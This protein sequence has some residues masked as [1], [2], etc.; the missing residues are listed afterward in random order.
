MQPVAGGGQRTEISAT[1]PGGMS[2]G[3]TVDNATGQVLGVN[4]YSLVGEEGVEQNFNMITDTSAP[5][6]FLQNHPA[7]PSCRTTV[8][9]WRSPRR[10]RL[11][12]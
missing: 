1:M 12:P 3:P 6:A 10:T 5:R 4:S 2:G 8:G 9:T 7:G 11:S